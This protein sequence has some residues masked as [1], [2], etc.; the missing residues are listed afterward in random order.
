MPLCGPVP[1]RRLSR[2]ACSL[3]RVRILCCQ[4]VLLLLTCTPGIK[5]FLEDLNP[6][7]LATIQT[8]FDKVDGQAAPVPN[9]TSADLSTLP[10]ASGSNKA[11]KTIDPMDD[12]FPR[13]EIDKLLVGTTILADSKSDAWKTRKEGLEALQG[14]LDVAANK[15]LKHTMGEF[16]DC[17]LI[18][19][20]LP[21]LFPVGDIGQVLKARIT[22][23][24]KAVQLIALDIVSRI[25]TGMNKPF[26]KHTRFFALPVATALADQKAHIRAAALQTLTS[27]ATACEGV[28]SMV[29]GL[30]TA[31]ESSNPVQRA[32]LLT[33]IAD[34]FKAHK[35]GPGLDLQP[36]VAPVVSCLED[37]NGDVR[38]GAQAV[39][40]FIIAGVGFDRVMRETSS[41]KP[42]SRS[43]VVPL[44]QAART[45]APAAPPPAV[46]AT[47]EPA[48]APSPVSSSPSPTTVQPAFGNGRS[49][50]VRSR[51]IQPPGSRPDSSISVRDDES[52]PPSRLTKPGSGLK[53]PASAASAKLSTA[54]PT[55]SSSSPFVGASPD[56]KK[57]RL[58]KDSTKWIIESNSSRKD[59]L[60]ILQ[61]QME[62]HVSRELNTL[63]FSHDH[64]AVND[65]ISGLGTIADC[66]AATLAGEEKYGLSISDM[67]AI[68]VANSDLPFKF[69]S[70]KVHESQPNLITKCLDV[71]DHVLAFLRGANY[72][73]TDQEALCFVPTIIHKVRCASCI[74]SLCPNLTNPFPSAWGCTGGCS[75]SCLADHT[76]TSESI[77]L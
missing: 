9:R 50:G 39:L 72:Q 3:E 74:I 23:T 31:L 52:A 69:V 53:R 20:M 58:A 75:C 37:R 13:V 7:L 38:K 25:A 63:L 71:V 36:W 1:H 11:G 26:E 2:C 22:D 27:I 73:L 5:D 48:K 19:L 42:A 54:S 67:K 76:D 55:T 68:L 33:W 77:C 65:H 51:K 56:A 46:P 16:L 59:L 30:G 45:S 62:P 29:N 44:I 24:N 6:Q 10:Q 18:S 12:L 8:E 17:S 47:I 40:P 21:V 14:I 70:L 28:D 32:S 49:T 4:T 57:T 43:M 34:W 64:N 35:G 66:Y 61:H 60:D 41:L 15:R